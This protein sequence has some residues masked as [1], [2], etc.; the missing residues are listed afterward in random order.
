[1]SKFLIIKATLPFCKELKIINKEL[2]KK[3]KEKSL[4]KC[5]SSKS[6]I[7]KKIIRPFLLDLLERKKD[8]SIYKLMIC[9]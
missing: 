5:Q 8:C 6:F 2:I 7:K 9:E 1:M 3:R 4:K